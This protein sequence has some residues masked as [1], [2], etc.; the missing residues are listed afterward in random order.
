MMTSQLCKYCGKLL[1]D[2]DNPFVPYCGRLCY[3]KARV[4]GR[5]APLRPC[6]LCGKAI[7]SHEHVYVKYCS[8]ACRTAAANARKKARRRS[9]MPAVKCILCGKELTEIKRG[10]RFYCTECAY[11]AKLERERRYYRERLA[12]RHKRWCIKCGK[13]AVHKS[14]TDFCSRCRRQLERKYGRFYE[15][16]FIEQRSS[17]VE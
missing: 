6:A 5:S 16:A 1:P 10:P 8:D 9:E 3:L 17:E 4:V 11:Q 15:T 2:E 13:V 14:G 7:P 12:G